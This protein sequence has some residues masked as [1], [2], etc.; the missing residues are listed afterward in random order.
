MARTH[1][2]KV[3]NTEMLCVNQDVYIDEMVLISRL[4]MSTFGMKFDNFYTR[5]S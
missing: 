4:E 2:L 5:S 3:K 1:F